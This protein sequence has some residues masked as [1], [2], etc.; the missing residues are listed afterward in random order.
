MTSPM[1]MSLLPDMQNCGLRMCRGCRVRFP[2]HRLQRK[3]LISDP[4]LHCGTCVTHAPW[5][6]SGSLTHGGRENVPGIPGACATCNFVYL[7]RGP[8]LP[9]FKV[10][11]MH[12][13]F[14]SLFVNL[15]QIQHHFDYVKKRWSRHSSTLYIN[16][17]MSNFRNTLRTI[18][19][20]LIVPWDM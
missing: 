2:R 12:N 17:Y 20:Q 8:W 5:Y 15:N 19:N 6:M 3:L 14:I 9:W 18:L 4:G 7:I 13:S 11:D 1:Q 10:L 16:R